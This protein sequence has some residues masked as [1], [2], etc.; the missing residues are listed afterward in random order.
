MEW[1]ASPSFQIKRSKKNDWR[2][3]WAKQK[4][5]SERERTFNSDGDGD[6]SVN[7]DVLNMNHQALSHEYIYYIL[8]LVARSPHGIALLFLTLFH[9]MCVSVIFPLICYIA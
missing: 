6:G 8:P 5:N 9:A 7:D 4:K 3:C 1:M 2:E